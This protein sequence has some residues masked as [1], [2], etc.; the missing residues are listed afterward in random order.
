MNSVRALS[1]SSFDGP[2]VNLPKLS[3]YIT[4]PGGSVLAPLTHRTTTIRPPSD[5]VNSQ[6][7]K[8]EVVPT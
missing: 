6:K 4:L 8:N 7:T 1:T 5:K 3:S 2:N